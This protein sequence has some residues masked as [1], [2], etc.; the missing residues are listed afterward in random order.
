MCILLLYFIIC[1]YCPS[2]LSY[3]WHNNYSRSFKKWVLDT[4]LDISTYISSKWLTITE[5][6]SIRSWNWWFTRTNNICS[7]IDTVHNYISRSL[8]AEVMKLHDAVQ[9][10]KNKSITSLSDI[11]IKPSHLVSW[12]TGLLVS[13][14]WLSSS[15]WGT[16]IICIR[17]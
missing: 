16:L 10:D 8:M 4:N 1:L 11:I 5:I 2:F 13:V 15:R 7:A 17:N 6:F 12:T 9:M 14:A 3:L